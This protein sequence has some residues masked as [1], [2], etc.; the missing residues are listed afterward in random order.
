MAERYA[1]DAALL[2]DSGTSAL[3]L[4]LASLGAG[5]SAPVRVALPAYGCYDL[6]TAAV[7]AGVEPVFY[8][9]DPETLGPDWPSL[10]VAVLA[11]VQAIVVVHLFGIPV[12]LDRMHA[13]SRATGAVL[14]E[15]AAQGAGAWWRHRR[16]GSNGD[17]GVLS[18]GR[19][20]G[21]TAGGGGALLAVGTRGQALLE[22]V[23]GRVARSR[24][25]FGNW[26]KLVAQALLSHPATYHAPARMPWL[27]LGETLYHE[28]WE[29]RAIGWAES[30]ALPVA[31]ELAD[32]AAEVRRHTA[33]RWTRD[34][35]SVGGVCRIQVPAVDGTRPG[36]LRFPVLLHE[37]SRR[38][39]AGAEAL[40]HG[41]IGGYPSP[42]PEL[43]AAG[44]RPA[45]ERWPGAARLA[46]Q[47]VTLPAHRWIRSDEVE[48]IAAILA[49]AGDPVAPGT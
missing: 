18:F 31:A 47:L 30:G 49:G 5:T 17:L 45:A 44:G 10:E 40:R 3:H 46:A 2:V 6:V 24:A 8:D 1:V 34:L 35:A 42:L 9:L 15:D 26:M 28:P 12:D 48:R 37:E 27:G 32:E 39:A 19:G 23:G 13:L 16:L 25:G 21:M 41:V 22:Q 38:W 33:A 4:A 43:P 20:K 14:V 7:G 36:W 29:P 11:G